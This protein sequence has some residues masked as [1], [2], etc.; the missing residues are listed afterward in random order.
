MDSG[1]GQAVEQYL[2]GAIETLQ[3]SPVDPKLPAE[4]YKVNALARQEA[5][6]ILRHIL[7]PFTDYQ[8]PEV[9]KNLEKNSLYYSHA[10]VRAI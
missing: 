5:L 8:E 9:K 4:Q 7:K 1:H 2:I 3:N 6:T 10:P